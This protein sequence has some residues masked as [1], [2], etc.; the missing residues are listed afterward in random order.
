MTDISQYSKD[1]KLNNSIWDKFVLRCKNLV[2]LRD[3][4]ILS[5]INYGSDH[6]ISEIVHKDSKRQVVLINNKKSAHLS[7]CIISIENEK[8]NRIML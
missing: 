2:L 7:F 8:G 6:Q 1:W 5:Q 3:E 4:F